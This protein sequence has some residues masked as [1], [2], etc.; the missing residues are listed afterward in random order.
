MQAVTPWNLPPSEFTF[1]EQEVHVWRVYLD[2][3]IVPVE[4]LNALLSADERSRADAYCFTQDRKRFIVG[5]GILRSL[6]GSYIGLDARHLI[7]CYGNAGKPMLSA[8]CRDALTFNVTHSHGIALYAVS[9]RRNVG[10]DI[11]HIRA[12]VQ[13]EEIAARFFS[14][15]EN[16]ILRSLPSEIRQLA[17]FNCWTRKE[18]FVKAKGGG[19]SIPFNQFQVAFTPGDKVALLHTKWDPFETKRWV[20]HPLNVGLDY[21]AALAADCFPFQVHCW[22]HP[23]TYQIDEAWS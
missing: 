7:F 15:E 22:N 2:Y 3:P 12:E 23:H 8:G 9:L 10:I 17:F 18:A 13:F 14:F 16:A 21:A 6:L 19:L 4:E 1:S 11:E 20:I 5:R